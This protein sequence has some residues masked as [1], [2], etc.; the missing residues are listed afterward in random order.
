MIIP[1]CLQKC[2][3]YKFKTYTNYS[4]GKYCQEA[5]RKKNNKLYLQVTDVEKF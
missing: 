5:K 4:L 2:I 1:K 3:K